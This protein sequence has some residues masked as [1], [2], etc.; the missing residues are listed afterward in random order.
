M[1]RYGY[2]ASNSVYV[3]TAHKAEHLSKYLKILDRIFKDIKKCE[4]GF[5]ITKLL[6]GPVCETSFRRIN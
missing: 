4:E 1:L 2:L 5:K 3:S 6:D